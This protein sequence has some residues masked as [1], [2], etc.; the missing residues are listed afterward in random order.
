VDDSLGS[1]SSLSISSM[2][3]STIIHNL[4]RRSTAADTGEGFV[5][6]IGKA[7]ESTLLVG[8]ACRMLVV[9]FVG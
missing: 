5:V 8:N 2:A 1:K 4:L 7:G 9:T 3:E 6:V